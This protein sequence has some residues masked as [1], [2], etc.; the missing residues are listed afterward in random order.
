MPKHPAKYMYI[1][2]KLRIGPKME[3]SKEVFYI[4]VTVHRKKF[5]YNKTN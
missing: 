1:C 4:Q 3:T 5:L 2:Q